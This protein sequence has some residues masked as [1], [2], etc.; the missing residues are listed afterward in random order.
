MLKDD[1]RINELTVALEKAER[2]LADRE[3][4]LNAAIE[5][6]SATRAQYEQAHERAESLRRKLTVKEA[7]IDN[8]LSK[9]QRITADLTARDEHIVV[10]QRKLQQ[11]DASIAS[12]KKSGNEDDVMAGIERE[13]SPPDPPQPAQQLA[14]MAIVLEPLDDHNTAH[15]ID[16]K[17]ITVGR[18]ATND[19]RIVSASVSRFHARIVIESDSIYLIDL[20]STNGCK[21][22]GQRISRH[23]IND[24]DVIEFGSVKFKLTFGP[25]PDVDDRSLEDTYPLLNDSAILIPQPIAGP[26]KITQN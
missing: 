8:L 21:V 16:K 3:T 22:N 12:L 4:L 10:L 25:T 1:S 19:I 5:Q 18:S 13:P 6:A 23:A 15:K 24:A 26:P 20:Q 2:R 9:A 11:R 7:E 17:T 14:A